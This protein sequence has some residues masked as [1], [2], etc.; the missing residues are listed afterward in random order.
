MCRLPVVEDFVTVL[1][2]CE[3][4]S[5]DISSSED[6]ECDDGFEFVRLLLSLR[7]WSG[8]NRDSLF[9]W[10]KHFVWLKGQMVSYMLSWLNSIA[11]VLPSST[12]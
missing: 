12:S 2:R 3:E 5:H 6:V 11:L 1:N 4:S 7:W 9:R 10:R 8:D